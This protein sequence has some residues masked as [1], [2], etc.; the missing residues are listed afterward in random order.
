MGWQDTLTAF[1]RDERVILTTIGVVSF[2]IVTTMISTLTIIRDDNEVPPVQPKTQY[3]TQDTENSL[4]LG[5]LDKLL[6]HPNYSIREIA[7]KI[8]YDRAVNDS[9]TTS[10]LLRGATQPDYDERIKSLRALEALVYPA[11]G[12]SPRGHTFPET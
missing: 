2:A 5:T 9:E 7:I 1:Y 12:K 6:D 10:F 8:L 4:Q 11:G 3:I